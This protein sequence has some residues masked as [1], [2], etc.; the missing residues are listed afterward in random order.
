MALMLLGCAIGAYAFYAISAI[1]P[2][3]FVIY[4]VKE[5]CG[6]ELEEIAYE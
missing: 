3:F 4:F 2:V 5:T 6:K 1:A